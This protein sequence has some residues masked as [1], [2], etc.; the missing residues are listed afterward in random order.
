MVLLPHILLSNSVNNFVPLLMY[1]ALEAS[2]E[3]STGLHP[4]ITFFVRTPEENPSLKC[5]RTSI[6]FIRTIMRRDRTSRST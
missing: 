3:S 5:S 4:Y 2:V 6:T 1:H